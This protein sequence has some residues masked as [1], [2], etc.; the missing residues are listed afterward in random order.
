MYFTN[1]G[2]GSREM[3]FDDG[4][5]QVDQIVHD[6]VRLL[7]DGHVRQQQG[8]QPLYQGSHRHGLMPRPTHHQADQAVH[9]LGHLRVERG[10]GVAH[11]EARAQRSVVGAVPCQH[12]GIVGP[13]GSRTFSMCPWT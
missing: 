8:Y 10:A 6:L 13:E 1:P 2:A 11:L 5:K 4:P 9:Q 3:D 7:I 12:E